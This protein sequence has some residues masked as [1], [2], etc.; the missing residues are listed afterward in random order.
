MAEIAE[1]ESRIK[2]ALARISAGLEAQSQAQADK[3]SETTA[4]QEA[5]EAEK[6]ANAQLEDRVR[7]LREGHEDQLSTLRESHEAQLREAMSDAADKISALEEQVNGLRTEA[8]E[9]RAQVRALRQ[10]NQR[11]QAS[12]TTLREAGAS[13]IEPHLINHAMMSEIEA[14]RATRA[15]EQ[16]ELDEILG[17]LQPMLEGS[18][19]QPAD[20]EGANA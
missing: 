20:E 2:D 3:G 18:S 5:L 16:T 11:L 13:E 12:L 7:T 15:A 1:L 6:M 9:A 19:E 17:A 8:S 4:L 14:M 10:S